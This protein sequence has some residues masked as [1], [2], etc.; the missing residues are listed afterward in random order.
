MS[1]KDWLPFGWWKKKKKPVAAKNIRRRAHFEVELLEKRWLFSTSVW[2]PRPPIEIGSAAN[3]NGDPILGPLDWALNP[4]YHTNTPGVT[5]NF[6]ISGSF[7]FDDS[8]VYTFQLHMAGYNA[9]NCMTF[10]DTGTSTFNLHE[11]GTFS[12]GVYSFNSFALNQSAVGSWH[13]VETTLS[14]SVVLDTTGTDTFSTT[15]TSPVFGDNFHWYGFNWWDLPITSSN[16]HNLS[17]TAYSWNSLTVNESGTFSL[18]TYQETGLATLTESAATFISDNDLSRPPG[19]LPA[20]PPVGDPTGGLSAVRPGASIPTGDAQTSSTLSFTFS[21]SANYTYTDCS[22]GTLSLH[23]EGTYGPVGNASFNLSSVLYRETGSKDT[24]S[25]TQN[26]INTVTGTGTIS[27]SALVALGIESGTYAGNS[28]FN[29][30][31]YS[32]YSYQEN[33][34]GTHTASEAGTYATSAFNL[35]TV[36]YNQ[37]ASGSFSFQETGTQSFS[38]T[39]NSTLSSSGKLTNADDY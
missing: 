26:G 21:Q 31:N 3:F 39:G 10:D 8:G 14:G 2:Q 17:L 18:F 19:G 22:N 35:P 29:S 37:T 36:L 28:T 25:L 32:S 38:G 24:Y 4:Q 9:T 12:N 6:Q 7:T 30:N 34:T 11:A 20:V 5:A 23:E 15:D 27:T 1:W 13:F 33:A 16:L